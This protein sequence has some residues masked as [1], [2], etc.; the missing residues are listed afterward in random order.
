MPLAA[1]VEDVQ[2]VPF[3]VSTLPA[4]PGETTWTAEVPL[5]SKTLFAVRVVAPVPPFATGSVPVTL[6]AKFTNVVDVDPVP[7][8]A[9]GRGAAKVKLLKCVIASPTSVP[10]L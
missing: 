2:A 10:L 9:T 1:G 3:E 4:V 7:P 6:V 5:P 8:E